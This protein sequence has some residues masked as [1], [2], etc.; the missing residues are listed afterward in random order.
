MLLGEAPLVKCAVSKEFF[1]AISLKKVLNYAVGGL[2]GKNP[3]LGMKCF[4]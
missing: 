1:R 3:K 4:H 2:H